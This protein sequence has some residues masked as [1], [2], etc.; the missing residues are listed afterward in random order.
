M[1]YRF[2]ELYKLSFYSVTLNNEVANERT[3]VYSQ[4]LKTDDY[5]ISSLMK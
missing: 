2:T 4:L 5:K 3:L 1:I